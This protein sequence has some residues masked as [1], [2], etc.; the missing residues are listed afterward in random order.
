MYMYM[1]AYI[2]TCIVLECI[3]IYICIYAHT[4]AHTQVRI[5]VVE[6]QICIAF[7]FAFPFYSPL[8]SSWPNRIEANQLSCSKAFHSSKIF[9]KQL[10]LSGKV[11]SLRFL[12]GQLKYNWLH[13]AQIKHLDSC[14]NVCCS[15]TD[16]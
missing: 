2:H 3:Y 11:G 10:M 6:T 5:I 13:I 4:Y 15:S 14:Q 12:F 9:P 1:H 7:T 16:V 8:C